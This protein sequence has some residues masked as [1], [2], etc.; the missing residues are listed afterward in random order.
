MEGAEPKKSVMKP[1]RAS[2]AIVTQVEDPVPSKLAEERPVNLRN[3]KLVKSK[4][5][6]PAQI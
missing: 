4:S 5:E 6:V 1:P 3:R 2:R